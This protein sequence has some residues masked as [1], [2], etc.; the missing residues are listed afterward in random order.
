MKMSDGKCTRDGFPGVR[1]TQLASKKTVY[2]TYLII[3]VVSWKVGA[4][5]Q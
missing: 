4:K 3:H 2:K 1:L 5:A